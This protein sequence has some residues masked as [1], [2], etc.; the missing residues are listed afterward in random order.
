[1]RLSRTAVEMHLGKTFADT[2]DAPFVTLLDVQMSRREVVDNLQLANMIAVR[3]LENTLKK[4]KIFTAKQLSEVDPMSLY[5]KRGVGSTQLFVAMS[6][7]DFHG[8]DCISWWDNF[9][10]K[11]KGA[12]HKRKTEDI[13]D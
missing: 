6:L 10:H 3:R 12:A 7:L 4:L 9:D 13:E 11:P 2:L 5:R 1:M 8:Y